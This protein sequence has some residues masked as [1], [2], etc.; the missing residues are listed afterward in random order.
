MKHQFKVQ[1]PFIAVLFLL[2]LASCVQNK[3]STH[4]YK[5]YS[6]KALPDSEVATLAFG[7]RVEEFSVDEVKV[8]RTD[9]GFVKLKP[10]VY[11]ISWKYRF[12]VSALVNSTGWDEIDATTSIELQAG[13][14][15][16]VN[17][18]RT[19]GHGYRM[20]LWISDETSGDQIFKKEI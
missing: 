8:K 13:H 14:T 11:Q 15:Y 20:I 5:S 3:A 6:G 17:A 7:E 9:Y 2:L 19:T 4:A 10:G 1:Y 16:T 18:D 12:A